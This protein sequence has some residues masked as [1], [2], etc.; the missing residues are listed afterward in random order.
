MEKFGRYLVGKDSLQIEHHWQN[1]YRT[2]HFRGAAIMGALSAL[3]IALWEIAGKH[4]GVPAY[5]LLGG[6]TRN[7]ARVYYQVYGDTREKLVQGVRD[8][9][10]AGFAAVGHLTPFLDEAKGVPFF[11]T[12]ADK[13][14]DAILK[15]VAAYREAAGTGVDLC[16]EIHRQLTS[17]ESITLAK[18]IE[19]FHPLFYKD[20]ILPD[21]FDAMGLVAQNVSIPIATGERLHSI[22]EFAMLLTRGAVQYIRPDVCLA[23]AA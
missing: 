22:H 7:K 11:K 15:A 12:H 18:G 17:T 2:S 9:R 23:G 21:N 1:M 4:F 6:K 13:M 16:I 20:P 10:E 14:G 19:Q 8:A 3:D 5:Q